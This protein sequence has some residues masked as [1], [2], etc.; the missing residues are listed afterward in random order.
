MSVLSPTRK[1]Y[2]VSRKCVPAVREGDSEPVQEACEVAMDF[3][4]AALGTSKYEGLLKWCAH[5]YGVDFGVSVSTKDV[6]DK[7]L[8]LPFT[9][10]SKCLPAV[11]FGSP[12]G[13]TRCSAGAPVDSKIVNTILRGRVPTARALEAAETAALD[14]MGLARAPLSKAK[15]GKPCALPSVTFS[16]WLDSADDS[17][18][19]SKTTL[20]DL[21]CAIGLGVNLSE[22]SQTL[23][24]VCDIL[25]ANYESVPECPDDGAGSVCCDSDD[26]SV[27]S[28][29][30]DEDD[31]AKDGPL[32][33]FRDGL[34]M[35]CAVINPPEAGA[36]GGGGDDC[37]RCC[38][39]K[40]DEEDEKPPGAGSRNHPLLGIITQMILFYMFFCRSAV[41]EDG[42][43][44]M[45][46]SPADQITN[47][48]RG[49]NAAAEA[50]FEEG[51]PMT[52]AYLESTFKTFLG[53][54]KAAKSSGA[55]GMNT[56]TVP[57]IDGVLFRCLAQDQRSETAK[58]SVE[59]LEA[60]LKW[61][62]ARDQGKPGTATMTSIMEIMVEDGELENDVAGME[63][64]RN[65]VLT[66]LK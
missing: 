14:A 5:V 34:P 42:K 57:N 22:E 29:T 59:N 18:E 55:D 62:V 2:S 33:C 45:T 66:T 12:A 17:S 36:A 24:E 47:A 61:F 65:L 13:S 49:Y 64:I 63:D 52:T 11:R 1:G 31:D 32:A 40:D 56:F 51:D 53:L 30:S 35:Y 6:H 21:V 10:H 48:M 16:N 4:A 39:G 44:C 58:V 7:M 3:W 46:M 60:Y 9:A 20:A 43:D 8:D 23:S 15:Y 41:C 19:T 50:Q 27:D 26:S 25:M 38:C 37:C 54:V 28:Y